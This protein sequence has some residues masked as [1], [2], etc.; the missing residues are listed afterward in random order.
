[1]ALIDAIKGSNFHFLRETHSQLKCSIM[2]R[3]PIPS[4]QPM[5]S[6][7]TLKKILGGRMITQKTTVLRFVTPKS[8]SPCPS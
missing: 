7:I 2:I 3:D 4:S 8:F 6:L 5:C 1:M